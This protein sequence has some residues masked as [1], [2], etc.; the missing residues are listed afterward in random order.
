MISWLF[1][2]SH[3]VIFWFVWMY[4]LRLLTV[5]KKM[6]SNGKLS[7]IAELYLFKNDIFRKLHF[8]YTSLIKMQINAFNLFILLNQ[9]FSKLVQHRQSYLPSTSEQ[10]WRFWI[11]CK[12]T[13][14]FSHLYSQVS[15]KLIIIPDNFLLKR[16]CLI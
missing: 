2:V 5:R 3:F 9:P 12:F 14:Y 1:T 4:F 8:D 16:I 15:E 6:I 7:K 11:S 10:G 13:F